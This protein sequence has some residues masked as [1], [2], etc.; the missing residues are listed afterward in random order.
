MEN[1]GKIE[2]EMVCESRLA[3]SSRLCV[4]GY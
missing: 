2:K 4:G 3:F 1:Y